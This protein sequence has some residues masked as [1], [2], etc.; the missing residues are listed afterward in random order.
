MSPFLPTLATSCSRILRFIFEVVTQS[1]QASPQY[2]FR[3][4]LQ[5]RTLANR[6][7]V[8]T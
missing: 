5:H 1:L 8:V 6:A 2:I 7:G 3:Y 4:A